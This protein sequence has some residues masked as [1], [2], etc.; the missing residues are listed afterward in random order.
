[1]M[2]FQLDCG[3]EVHE[4]LDLDNRNTWWTWYTLSQSDSIECLRVL[5][6]FLLERGAYRDIKAMLPEDRDSVRFLS[7]WQGSMIEC[8]ET[9]RLALYYH[10]LGTK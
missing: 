2:S 8:V 6:V 7:V 3:L 9:M 4:M 10:R 5:H 1:M